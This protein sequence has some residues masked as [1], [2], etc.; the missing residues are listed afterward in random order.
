MKKEN[1]KYVEIDSSKIHDKPQHQTWWMDNDKRLSLQ[2]QGN[3]PC[4]HQLLPP[5]KDLD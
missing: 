1:T 5:F 2:S 4:L 3:R